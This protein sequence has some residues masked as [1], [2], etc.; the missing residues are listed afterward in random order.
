MAV[1][2]ITLEAGEYDITGGDLDIT[3]PWT[4]QD[5]SDGEWIEQDGG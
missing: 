5:D 3:K 2:T 4:V 1:I